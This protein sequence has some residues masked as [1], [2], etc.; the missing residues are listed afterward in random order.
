MRSPP[1]DP[2]AAAALLREARRAWR[3]TALADL[4]DVPP[5]RASAQAAHE[6]WR[7]VTDRLAGALIAAGAAEEALGPAADAVAD[8][9]LREPAVLLLVRA[10]AGTGQA[11]RA[12][13]TAREFRSPAGRGDRSRSLAG[14][15]GARERGGRRHGR[16]RRARRGPAPECDRSRHR[17][18]CTDGTASSPPSS[19]CS[20]PSGW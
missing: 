10:Q 3:G 7:D 19:G 16:R 20:S 11:P 6:L 13:R 8:D 5:L 17:P 4:A 12:L 14:A 1:T 9:P 18:T 2:G 15:G